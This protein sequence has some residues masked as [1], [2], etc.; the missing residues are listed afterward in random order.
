VQRISTNEMVAFRHTLAVC[1]ENNIEVTLAI[2]PVHALDLELLRAGDNW[3]RFEE[4][5]R[6]VVRTV[7]EEW[8]GGRVTVWDFTGY[9]QPTTEEVPP[10]GDTVTRMKYYFESSH[11]TPAMGALML[12]C[13]FGNATNEFGGTISTANIEAHLQ[14]IREQRESY[15]RTHAAD[16][17][18]VQRIAK[19]VLAAR[20]PTAAIVED[21][22]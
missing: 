6:D 8:P 15:A 22:E 10:A 9:W 3:E 13:M 14:K 20:K 16:I 4:W 19:Q 1:R 5:K 18:L 11:Y 2:N 12:D 17:Q 21:V 7:A